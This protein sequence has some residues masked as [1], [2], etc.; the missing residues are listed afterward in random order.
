MG[1]YGNT[2]EA[3]SA[4]R[5]ADRDSLPDDWEIEFFGDL[6]QNAS[7]DP[8]GNQIS[9]A[10]EYRRGLDPKVPEAMPGLWYVD[11]AVQASGDGKSWEKAFKTIQEGINAASHGHVVTVGQ[12]IY[13]ENV[14]FKSQNIVLRSTNPLDPTVVAGTIIDGTQT[15][16][17]VTFTG[18]EDETCVLSGFTIRNGTDAGGIWG[19]WSENRARATIENNVISANFGRG[20]SACDG[21]IQNNTIAGNLG[22][23]LYGCKGKIENNTITNDSAGAG[24]G[25]AYCNGMIIGNTITGNMAAEGGGL[26]ECNST[27]QNNTISGNSADKEPGYGGGLSQ[28]DGTIRTNVITGNS[29][30]YGGGLYECSALIEDCTVT[31]NKAE[32]GGAICGGR[33]TVRNTTVSENQARFDGGGFRGC[34]ATIQGNI[35]SKNS[36]GNDGGAFCFC[37]GIIENNLILEN[38]A[39]NGG[40]LGFCYGTIRNNTVFGN[41]ASEYGAGLFRCSAAVTIQNCIVWGNSSGYGDQVYLSSTPTYSCTQN[42]AGGGVGSMDYYPYFVD[43]TNGDYHLKSYSPCIDAGD[44]ASPFSLE[45]QPNGGRIDMG[46]YGNTP[47]ATPRSLDSDRDGLPDDWET[48]TFGDLSQDGTGDPDGDMIPNIQEYR[49]AKDPKVPGTMWHVDASASASGDGRSWQTAFRTIQEGIEAAVEGDTVLVARGVYRENVRFDGRNIRL[50]SVDPLD[51]EMV[52]ATIMDGNRSGSVVT[53]A[54]TEN[55]SPNGI[56]HSKWTSGER[57]GNSR[58]G[59]ET[60][61]RPTIR[62]NMIIDNLASGENGKGGGLASCHGTIENNVIARNIASGKYAHGGGLTYCNGLIQNNTIADNRA[63]NDG[64]GLDRCSGTVRNCIIWG[65]RSRSRLQ[66]YE[67]SLPTYSCIEDWLNGGTGNIVLDLRF[68]NAAAADYRLRSWSPCVDAGDPSSPYFNEPE[69]NGGRIDMGAYGNTP[70]ATS[71]SRDADGDGLPDDWE[72]HEFAN[73]GQNATSDPDGDGIMNA[74]ECRFGWSPLAASSTL[75]NNV[76]KKTGYQTIQAALHEAGDGDDVVVSPGTYVENIGFMGK[77]VVLR[78]TDPTEDDIVN[79]TIIEGSDAGVTVLF[80]GGETSSCVLSGFTVR[81][82]YGLHGGGISGNGTHATI[83]HNLISNNFAWYEG[84]GIWD[85]DGLIRNNRIIGNSTDQSSGGGL[86]RCDGNIE[87]KTIA[88]NTGHEAGGLG[89]CQGV[90]R[91]NLIRGNQASWEGGGLGF[92]GGDIIE[93]TISGNRAWDGGGGL[94][95]CNGLVGRNTII[96]N[97]T[98]TYGGGLRDCNGK[99][100]NNIIA[101]KHA[102]GSGGGISY[103]RGTI[104][105]NTIVCNSS[106]Y[107]SGGISWSSGMIVNCIVWGN[108]QGDSMVNQL[109]ES[110]SPEYCCIQNWTACGW[111]NISA[112]PLFISPAYANYHLSRLSPCIEAG[113]SE[114]PAPPPTD[115]DEETRPSGSRMDIGADERVDADQDELPDYWETSHFATTSFGAADDSDDDGL[116]NIQELSRSTNPNNSDTDTDG[117]GDKDEILEG[118][119]RLYAASLFRVTEVVLDKSGLTLTW[120]AMSGKTYQVYLSTD[121]RTWSRLGTPVGAMPWDNI[122]ALSD[123]Q[124]GSRRRCFYRVRVLPQKD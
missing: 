82:G 60:Y 6:A 68:V 42:W 111:G 57:R 113:T 96:G 69:P 122:M 107:E 51:F 56:H 43:P 29:A 37:H 31:E 28:C 98:H 11:G 94:A 9:N 105:N 41:R 83:Q 50:T 80:S 59:M 114:I 2:P 46:A 20:I 14:E 53:F 117:K 1:S 7:G 52:A 67:S 47:E 99:V 22:G 62:D 123:S 16:R 70:N 13:L 71:K 55:M 21:I 26:Y 90:I 65:N 110:S 45:P 84:E 35:I 93:N 36:A 81:S 77:N 27:I 12:G 92:C 88:E 104:Q 124:A 25:L 4:S 8:D 49:Y 95:D 19:G 115:I 38:S 72:L 100:G 86:S 44:P 73:L 106:Q 39:T 85:C 18:F 121:M 32:M 112:D 116:T 97:W 102:D 23:G 58:G 54:G 63:T 64:G 118:T 15:G 34:N 3:T 40:G 74:V 61:T 48:E 10:D 119:D 76:T 17:P 33:G 103:C 87:A 5:D 24:G 109:D 79:S 120:P 78:S 75:A 30:R 101:E 91:G 89:Y 66:L 108:K